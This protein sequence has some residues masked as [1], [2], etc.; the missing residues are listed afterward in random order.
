ME[1]KAGNLEAA[2]AD[3]DE[4]LQLKPQN[5]SSLYGRG[6]AKTLQGAK[7]SGASD[8]AAARMGAPGID[9]AAAALGFEP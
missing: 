8:I 4:S 7:E 2:A 3:F 6:L 1:L 9:R 5:P